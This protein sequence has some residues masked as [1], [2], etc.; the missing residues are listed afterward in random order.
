MIT[1]IYQVDIYCMF[2]Q[3]FKTE[4]MLLSWEAEHMICHGSHE[5]TVAK[6]LWNIYLVTKAN[7]LVT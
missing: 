3:N 7:N 6:Q 2:N 4:F 5:Y 1:Y